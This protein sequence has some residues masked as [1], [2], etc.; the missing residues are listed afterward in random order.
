M[1]TK[2]IRTSLGK[3][4]FL[5]GLAIFTVVFGHTLKGTSFSQFPVLSRVLNQYCFPLIYG[6]FLCFFLIS[7]YYFR[8]KSIKATLLSEIKMV[9]KPLLW[10]LL[11][12]LL[13][14]F[15]VTVLLFEYE[16]LDSLRI[17]LGFALGLREDI[18]LFGEKLLFIGPIWFL[19]GSI[20]AIFFLNLILKYVPEKWQIPVDL[21]GFLISG[22]LESFGFFPYY[23]IQAALNVLP[24]CHVGYLAH[25]KKLLQ[26]LSLKIIWTVLAV[27][28]VFTVLNGCLLGINKYF[29]AYLWGVFFFAVATLYPPK[30][31]RIVEF[32]S[33]LGR[34]SLYVLCAHSVEYT[35][36]HDLW[37][38]IREHFSFS[39]VLGGLAVFLA[40]SA[41]IT[42][43]C[44]FVFFVKRL[45]MKSFVD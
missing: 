36:C 24:L 32:F 12:E 39:P 20:W 1:E 3:Y 15:S 9:W 38:V 21:V 45:Q 26:K 44:F 41:F 13:V 11:A 5:K 18:T 28:S 25:K 35:A 37:S 4:D 22:I 29:V 19:L 2:R 8:V 33:F 34:Y 30:G 27:L 16:L 31:G 42:L 7:G 17:I 40:R 10:T 43:A 14:H 23:C 6:L